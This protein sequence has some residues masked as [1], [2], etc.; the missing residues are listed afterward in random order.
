MD[1][2]GV[3]SKNK[4]FNACMWIVVAFSV[5][6]YSLFKYGFDAVYDWFK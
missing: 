2:H 3:G 6:V 4:V 5:L 1:M